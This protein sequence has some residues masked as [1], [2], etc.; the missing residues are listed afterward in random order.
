MSG[1]WESSD[2]KARLPPE[3]HRLRGHVRKRAGGRCEQILDDGSRCPEVGTDCDH[4]RAGDDHD[5]TNLA[6]LCST[7]HAK[8]SSREG[9]QALRAATARLRRP[10]VK[11][12]GLL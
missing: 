12:P 5:P 7:H 1:K 9:S 3:W 4:V 8:K 10:A 11:H 6:W 2:R